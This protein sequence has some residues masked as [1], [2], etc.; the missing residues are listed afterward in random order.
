MIGQP[1]VSHHLKVLTETGFVLFERHGTT[2]RYRINEGCLECFPSAAELVMGR[3]PRY[4]GKPA[5]C[6]APWMEEEQD[7]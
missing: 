2:S 6:A 4:E 3:L 5:A 1:T 7:G